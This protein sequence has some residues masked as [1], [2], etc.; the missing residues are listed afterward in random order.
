MLRNDLAGWSGTVPRGVRRS[1]GQGWRSSDSSGTGET[2]LTTH[3]FPAPPEPRAAAEGPACSGE[4]CADAKDLGGAFDGSDRPGLPNRIRP[5]VV[6]GRRERPWGALLPVATL[7]GG[8]VAAGVWRT[9]RDLRHQDGG[10]LPGDVRRRFAWVN[11]LQWSAIIAVA[12]GAQTSGRPELIFGLVAVVVGL[13]FLPLAALF[14]QPR[15][16]VTGGLMTATGARTA[17]PRQHGGTGR[18]SGMG[19]GRARRTPPRQ[20]GFRPPSIRPGP[21]GLSTSRVAGPPVEPFRGRGLCGGLDPRS[22]E[23]VPL[24]CADWPHFMRRSFTASGTEAPAPIGSQRQPRTGLAPTRLGRNGVDSPQGEASVAMTGRRPTPAASGSP[25]SGAP[26]LSCAKG[27]C[28]AL[29]PVAGQ[30][31]V[32]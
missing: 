2:I 13:H 4:R 12:G 3:G 15:F 21:A 27:G 5:R 9:G 19:A 22:P 26:R 17:R 28:D 24:P 11:A 16:H 31:M 1:G 8:A 18:L 23:P 7:A 30:P 32:K 10:P 6:A 20:R 14:R 25:A 29:K